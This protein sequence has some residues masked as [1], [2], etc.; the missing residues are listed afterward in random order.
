MEETEVLAA[1]RVVKVVPAAVGVAR[2]ARVPLVVGVVER[3]VV[4]G[5]RC[6]SAH[7]SRAV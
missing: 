6:P 5:A 1:V 3:A 2:G 4:R 7:A